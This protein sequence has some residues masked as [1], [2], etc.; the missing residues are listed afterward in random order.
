ML[1]ELG[2]VVV[3]E[4]HAQ[5]EYMVQPPIQKLDALE[6]DSGEAT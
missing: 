5:V 4:L 3:G 2:G 1:M 6:V